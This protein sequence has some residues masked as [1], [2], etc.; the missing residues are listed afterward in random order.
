MKMKQIGKTI[1]ENYLNDG[2]L[3]C[4]KTNMDG[5]DVVKIGKTSMKLKDDED[6]VITKLQRRYN[7]YYPQY[8]MLYFVR[9]FD[10]NTAERE[11]FQKIIDLKLKD[12][13]ELF[14]YDRER[15]DV[16]FG[17]ITEKFPSIH[18]LINKLEPEELTSLNEKIRKIEGESI[19]DEY[20][21]QHQRNLKH[22]TQV[23]QSSQPKNAK[24]AR[25]D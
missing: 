24:R 8:D 16:A 25:L 1:Y 5:K 18:D 10:H 22:T 13:C 21:K 11:L 2:Y 6:D 3:Y 12:R 17:E 14:E 4:I 7:T 9:V 15:I 23:H 20:T 19:K